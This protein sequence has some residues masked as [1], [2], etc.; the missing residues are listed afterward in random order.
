MKWLKRKQTPPARLLST[1]LTR[2]VLAMLEVQRYLFSPA[3][4]EDV[5]RLIAHNI[6]YWKPEG[7]SAEQMER[8]DRRILEKMVWA[9]ASGAPITQFEADIHAQ[10][11]MPEVPHDRR[12]P[13]RTGRRARPRVSRLLSRV[14]DRD[15]L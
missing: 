13:S 15:R 8:I 4:R 6:T 3:E 12:V 11:T 14:A 7:W 10:L 5:L 1:Q 9:I 2:D